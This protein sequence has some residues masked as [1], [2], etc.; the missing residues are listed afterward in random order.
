[1]VEFIK[2]D[3]ADVVEAHVTVRLRREGDIVLGRVT[4]VGTGQGGDEIVSTED[5]DPPV[6]FALRIARDLATA[7]GSPRIDVVD[8]DGLWTGSLGVL[9]S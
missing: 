1:M 5:D 7:K 6:E 2:I 8:P 9:Q 3:E 4:T